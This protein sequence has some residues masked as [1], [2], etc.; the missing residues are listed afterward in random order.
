M[1][2]R[3]LLDAIDNI[4]TIT[5][6]TKIIGKDLNWHKVEF[7]KKVSVYKTTCKPNT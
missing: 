5:K 6:N 3:S 7:M 4:I 1:R 2:T